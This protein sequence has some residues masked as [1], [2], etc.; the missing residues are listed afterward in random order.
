MYIVFIRENVLLENGNEFWA[1]YRCFQDIKKSGSILVL[2]NMKTSNKMAEIGEYKHK[3]QWNIWKSIVIMFPTNR[4]GGRTV[5]SG[6]VA[7]IIE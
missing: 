3:V 1:I 6:R 7:T 4:E 5:G 2:K